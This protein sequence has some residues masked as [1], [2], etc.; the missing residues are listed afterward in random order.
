MVGGGGVVVNRGRLVV[1]GGGLMVDRGG[2]VS[3][4]NRGNLDN[5]GGLVDDWGG[6]V[7]SRSRHHNRGRLVGGGGGDNNRG[8]GNLHH[9]GG[10]GLVGSRSGGVRLG[11]GLVGGLLRVDGGALV[12]D[13]GNVTLGS[14]GVGHDLDPAVGEVDPV[15]SLGVV[16]LPVLLV[17]EHSSGVLGIADSKLVLKQYSHMYSGQ[18][19]SHD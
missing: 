8:G 10:G 9:G 11:G 4:D 18:I 14:G 2:L 3:G 1:D 17:R 5:R 12:G 13:I 19:F 6:L 7:G 16:V 15:L